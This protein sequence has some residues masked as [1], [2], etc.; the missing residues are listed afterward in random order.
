MLLI[1]QLIFRC[2]GPSVKFAKRL[3]L[4]IAIIYLLPALASAG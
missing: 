4:A 2:T 1:A 3:L